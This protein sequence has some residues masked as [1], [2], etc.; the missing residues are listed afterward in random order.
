M[1][2][3]LVKKGRFSYSLAENSGP[4]SKDLFPAS[5]ATFR[6]SSRR[7]IRSYEGISVYLHVSRFHGGYSSHPTVVGCVIVRSSTLIATFQ[8]NKLPPFS[9]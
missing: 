5:D 2:F 9:V 3:L 8:T 6:C 4:V 1:Y 7:R